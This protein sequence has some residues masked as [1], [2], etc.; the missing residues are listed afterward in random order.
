[1]GGGGHNPFLM[2]AKACS[3]SLES[4]PLAVLPSAC[5]PHSSPSQPAQWQCG[6]KGRRRGRGG[7]SHGGRALA[8]ASVSVPSVPSLATNTSS[9]Y[10]AGAFRPWVGT[11]NQGWVSVDVTPYP[12][13]PR[14]SSLLR[15]SGQPSM[16]CP[17][18]KLAGPDR[19][20]L[21]I[22]DRQPGL[23]TPPVY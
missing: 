15:A 2:G 7:E 21:I 5:R 1:M 16:P 8:I 3:L 11:G 13:G 22:S 17:S 10:P 4:K 23:E 6:S 12:G 20:G 19:S 18:L 14:A 9:P